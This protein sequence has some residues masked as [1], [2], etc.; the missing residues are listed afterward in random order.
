[1]SLK[2]RERAK[3]SLSAWS[4]GVS[5]AALPECCTQGKPVRAFWDGSARWGSLNIFASRRVFGAKV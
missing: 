5:L 3:R 2:A 1:M 4:A